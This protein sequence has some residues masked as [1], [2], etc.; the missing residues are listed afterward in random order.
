MIHGFRAAPAPR[1]DVPVVSWALFGAALGAGARLAR[2]LLDGPRMRDL[3]LLLL[4]AMT[5]CATNAGTDCLSDGP[6]RFFDPQ[7]GGCIL[8]GDREACDSCGGPQC[9]VGDGSA[10]DLALCDEGCAS[11]TEMTC[12]GQ[13]GCIAAYV[14]GSFAYCRGTAPSGPVHSGACAGLDAH[15]CARHDN[16]AAWY[17]HRVSGAMSFDHCADEVRASTSAPADGG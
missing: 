6:E 13:P 4:L 11:F 2:R 10:M 14:D 9:V 8:V 17:L 1:G 12:L 15:E 5:G 7:S 16:C 3:V